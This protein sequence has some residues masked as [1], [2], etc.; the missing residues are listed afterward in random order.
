MSVNLKKYWKLEYTVTLFLVFGVI[1]LLLP[2]SFENSIQARFISKWNEIYSNTGYTFS[3]IRAHI[4][5]DI[6]K[7]F[8]EAKSSQEQ[9]KLLLQLI[10]PYMRIDTEN[11]PKNYNLHYMNKSRV[12]KGD[13]YYFEDVYFTD[14]GNVVGIKDIKEQ[15]DEPMF[16]MMFDVNGVLPPN[17]WGRDVF[18]INIFED[19]IEPFGQNLP[20]DELQKD[21][22]NNGSGV[23]CSYYYRIGGGFDG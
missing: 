2:V 15:G 17:R 13:L 9:E 10:K 22:S 7:S 20:T 16:I 19:R 18:G 14:N 4:S 11:T 1:L 12:K 5:D 8:N 3:V 6:L 21:C 23:Y